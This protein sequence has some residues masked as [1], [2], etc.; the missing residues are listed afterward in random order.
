MKQQYSI[1]A[2]GSRANTNTRNIYFWGKPSIA[3]G[4]GRGR[5]RR[6]GGEEG[7]RGRGRGEGRRGVYGAKR[8]R[9]F[10]CNS[11]PSPTSLF[12]FFKYHSI[13]RH[14]THSK[15]IILHD[16]DYEYTIING[17]VD[18]PPPFFFYE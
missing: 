18:T 17:A 14:C 1:A 3:G 16:H 10:F 13:A 5:G 9:D 15:V 8:P 2:P 6:G 7:G 4:G 11:V 12:F